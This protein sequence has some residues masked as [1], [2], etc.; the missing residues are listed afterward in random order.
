[1]FKSGHSYSLD[2]YWYP[3]VYSSSANQAI[4]ST[5]LKEFWMSYTFRP[6]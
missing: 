3:I 5:A 4:F 6:L 2:I 1:V